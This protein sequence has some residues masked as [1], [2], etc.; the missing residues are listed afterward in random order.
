LYKGKPIVYGL[1][2]LIFDHLH[3]PAGWCEGYA[4][5]LE[6]SATNQEFLGFDIIPYS[7]SLEQGGLELMSGDLYQV[8]MSGLETQRKNVE[9][10]AAFEREWQLFCESQ[11]SFAIM[12]SYSPIRPQAL[13]WLDRHFSIHKWLLPKSVLNFRLNAIRCESH[14][15]LLISVL[16][17]KRKSAS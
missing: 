1:G 13:Y 6:Y 8:F 16:E 7:Q 15:E 5:K 12:R 9:S 14:R 10:N 11:S 4:L 3:P 17:K 2:N